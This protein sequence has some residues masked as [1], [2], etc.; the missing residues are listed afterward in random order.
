M[1][2]SVSR[3]KIPKVKSKPQS[4]KESHHRAKV[5]NC[6]CSDFLHSMSLLA[7]GEW[8][9]EDSR[10]AKVVLTDLKTGEFKGCGGRF[11]FFS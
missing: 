2:K 7:E 4:L 8:S 10:N 6:H 1:Q 9:N 11:K 3:V 5:K